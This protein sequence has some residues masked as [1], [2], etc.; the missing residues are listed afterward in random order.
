MS[1][2]TTFDDSHG[3]ETMV[4]NHHGKIFAILPSYDQH[5]GD[6]LPI[7]PTTPSGAT[8]GSDMLADTPPGNQH[9]TASGTAPVYSDEFLFNSGPHSDHTPATKTEAV[10]DIMSGMCS[11]DIVKAVNGTGEDVLEEGD[12][13]ELKDM[14]INQLVAW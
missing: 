11:N 12:E 9:R 7:N 2:T 8:D 14:D 13:E 3:A 5:F 4:S 1:T 6:K 10:N